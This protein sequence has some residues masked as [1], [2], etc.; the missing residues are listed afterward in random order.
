MSSEA[1]SKK[2]FIDF[3]TFSDYSKKIE[4]TRNGLNAYAG[5]ADK[6]GMSSRQLAAMRMVPAQ[7]TDIVV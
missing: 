5:Q 2:G 6:A 3:D 7:M 1:I 4:E